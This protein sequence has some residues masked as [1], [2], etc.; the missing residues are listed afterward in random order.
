MLVLREQF[1]FLHM[2]NDFVPYH[3]FHNLTQNGCNTDWP[4]I[5]HLRFRTLLMYRRYVGN[6]PVLWKPPFSQWRSENVVKWFRNFICQFFFSILGC[7]PSAQG[8]LLV[9]NLKS[10]F[11]MLSAVNLTSTSGLG[12]SLWMSSGMLVWS[13]LIKTL[14]KNLFKTWHYSPLLVMSSRFSF[15]RS[16]F[17]R[18]DFILSFT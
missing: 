16:D 17:G 3:S 2:V 14:E 9:F 15:L 12:T 6:A 13:S 1:F 4:E 8:D 10:L 5:P 11:F 18:C 7:S